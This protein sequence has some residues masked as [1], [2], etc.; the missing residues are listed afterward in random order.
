MGVIKGTVR[1]Q[2]QDYVLEVV[3]RK[4]DSSVTY[5]I[6]TSSGCKGIS[7]HKNRKTPGKT[8]NDSE[9]KK[10]TNEKGVGI[11]TV[12]ARHQRWRQYRISTE[13]K[14]QQM[15]EKW[16]NYKKYHL[17]RTNLLTI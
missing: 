11:Y 14:S 3:V 17:K 15:V 12:D 4:S 6:K 9:K 16:I 10:G 1:H 2:K 13:G 7:R 5:R 8:F